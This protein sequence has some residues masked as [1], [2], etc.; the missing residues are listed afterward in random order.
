AENAL[1]TSASSLRDESARQ[2]LRTSVALIRQ[3]GRAIL[4]RSAGS[5]GSAE[6]RHAARGTLNVVMGW[7][8]V[9]HARRGDETA[10]LRAVDVIERSLRTLVQ[11]LDPADGSR[12]PASEP[13]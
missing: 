5:D 13:S 8:R 11:R 3:M 9:L 1:K 2:A 12:H 7:S 6:L 10:V 4:A